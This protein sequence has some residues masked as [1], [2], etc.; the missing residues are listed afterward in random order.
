MYCLFVFREH[1]ENDV[2]VSSENMSDLDQDV[3]GTQLISLRNQRK[4]KKSK[5]NLSKKG[6]LEAQ[7]RR[8]QT[9]NTNSSLINYEYHPIVTFFND[10]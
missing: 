2:Y 10:Y 8:R 1:S 9:G 5:K 4:N 3:S 7:N 6:N